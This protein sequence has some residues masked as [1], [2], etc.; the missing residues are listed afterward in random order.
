MRRVA[1]APAAIS[2][3]FML[4]L[5]LGVQASR[6]DSRASAA[7]AFCPGKFRWSVKTMSDAAATEAWAS[8][9]ATVTTVH[10]LVQRTDRP[11]HLNKN[12]P[13]QSGTERTKFRVRGV[14]LVWAKLEDQLQ[15]DEDGDIH[16]V[17]ADPTSG[18]T[19]IA[20]FPDT[21]CAPASSSSKKVQML[22]ARNAFVAACKGL[23]PTGHFERLHGSATI[24]GV[25]F[26]DANHRQRGVAKTNAIELHP[27]LSFTKATC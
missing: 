12:T 14:K 13:R 8:A 20:E 6:P 1:I 3:A 24:T 18:E 22:K 16:L 4:A 17:I 23:P 7:A 2:L 5:V 21:S 15:S 9:S 27:V 26:Y 19:M 10:E 25:G 11:A